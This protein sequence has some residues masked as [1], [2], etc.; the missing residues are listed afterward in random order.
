M[1]DL[2]LAPFGC[3]IEG[4]AIV[5][6]DGMIS[7][8][9]GEMPAKLRSGVDWQLFQTALDAAALVVIGREG[10]ERHSA[11][12]RRRLVFT[13]SVDGIAP[14][15]KDP[16]TTRF[17]PA[18]AT[19]K[20]VLE[21][22][23]INRGVI[24]VTGGTRI[25]DYF[26][27]SYDAFVLAE[28]NTYTLPNGRPCFTGMHPRVALTKGGLVPTSVTMLEPSRNITSTIWHTSA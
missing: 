7:D 26:L 5:S 8:A 25:F 28:T 4:H 10:H 14:D 22:L 2:R 18:G 12:G 1:M 23:N 20:E 11:K 3:R 17:N 24:A 13:S 21:A 6:A 15:R 27:G 19:L 16:L 9:N